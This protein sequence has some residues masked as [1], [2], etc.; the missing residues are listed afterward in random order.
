MLRYINLSMS[1]ILT[2]R[3]LARGV[4]Y[5]KFPCRMIQGILKLQTNRPHVFNIREIPH[6][7]LLWRGGNSNARFSL[8]LY[9]NLGHQHELPKNNRGIEDRVLKPCDHFKI[10][11]GPLWS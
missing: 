3:T 6:L 4:S 9:H 2:V 11:Q 10:N 1:R 7:I 5:A 8:I